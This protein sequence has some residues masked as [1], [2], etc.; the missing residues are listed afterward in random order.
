[1][2]PDQPLQGYYCS[3]CAL[4]G[5]DKHSSWGLVLDIVRSTV[6]VVSH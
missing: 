5:G 3:N 6:V 2:V 1:M 4:F